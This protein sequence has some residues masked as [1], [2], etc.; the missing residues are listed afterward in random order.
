[1]KKGIKIIILLLYLFSNS[2]CA[3]KTQ[4]RE[5]NNIDFLFGTWIF[6]G[7]PES[8][9]LILQKD[10][11]SL[12][13]NYEH[14]Q[15]ELFRY[16]YFF[17]RNNDSIFIETH[18]NHLSLRI[19][20]VLF[21][22]NNAVIAYYK[23]GMDT[24]DHF[25]N[26]HKIIKVIDTKNN[27]I[28]GELF[29][30]D[31]HMFPKDIFIIPECLSGVIAF[32]YDQSDGLEPYIDNNGN[33]V[34]SIDSCDFFIKLK[35]KPDL[36]N[37][38]YKNIFFNYRTSQG[39]LQP[40]SLYSMNDT[41]DGTLDTSNS[42]IFLVGFDRIARSRFNEI[43]GDK[44]NGNILFAKISKNNSY[45]TKLLVQDS[46]RYKGRYLKFYEDF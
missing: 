11:I 34:Y 43:V 26:I 21:N 30:P 29:A 27:S 10:T 25:S 5:V 2:S 16:S 6:E 41:I 14:N 23:G 24:K 28:N 38:M 45:S 18:E 1:M 40:L 42:H 35:Y 4:S 19:L 33:R 13:T 44:I 20:I 15:L 37:F 32:V 36:V 12:V 9:R 3:Q 46:L 31:L 8:H 39:T 22:E 7:F 17:S